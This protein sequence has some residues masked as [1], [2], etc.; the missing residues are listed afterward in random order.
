MI[1]AALDAPLPDVPASLSVLKE[2]EEAA[3]ALDLPL[4]GEEW[5]ERLAIKKKGGGMHFDDGE[6]ARASAAHA[7][8]RAVLGGDVALA[9]RRAQGD[10]R[11]GRRRLPHQEWGAQLTA[12]Q[13]R[14]T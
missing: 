6:R 8:D 1:T 10:D 14:S 3:D 2:V 4:T 13:T 7:S 11:L 5:G 9:A 12:P